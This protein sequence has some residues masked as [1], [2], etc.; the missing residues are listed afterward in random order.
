MIFLAPGTQGFI[1]RFVRAI[2]EFAR[3]KVKAYEIKG[4]VIR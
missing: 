2:L 3:A 1:G 4:C